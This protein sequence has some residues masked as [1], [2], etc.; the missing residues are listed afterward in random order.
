MLYS[1]NSNY[2][3]IPSKITLILKYIFMFIFGKIQQELWIIE[4][5][6]SLLMGGHEVWRGRVW[7]VIEYWAG[8]GVQSFILDI[9]YSEI[10]PQPQSM[11]SY[12]LL[13][14]QTVYC[15]ADCPNLNY[16]QW[17]KVSILHISNLRNWSET[18]NNGR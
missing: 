5:K 9:K 12:S 11:A 14:P 2:T 10:I 17:K 13:T 1:E 18:F 7:I 15:S 8:R 6:I 4:R 16:F 3:Y